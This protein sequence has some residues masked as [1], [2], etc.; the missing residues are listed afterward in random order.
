M[1]AKYR[2]W[3]LTIFCALGLFALTSPAQAHYGRCYGHY[4]GCYYGGY[5]YGGGSALIYNS[6]DGKYY[7]I[8]GNR[9][10]LYRSVDG[11]FYPVAHYGA[12]CYKMRH[13]YSCHRVT[14]DCQV[15][16]AHWVGTHWYGDSR[17]CWYR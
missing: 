9:G 3:W 15:R 5:G 7:P 14:V 8:P 12:C 17:V 2:V 16:P 1:K 10:M 6:E 4:H 13:H 11:Q